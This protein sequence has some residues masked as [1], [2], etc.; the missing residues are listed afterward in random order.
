MA[1][2]Q[3]LRPEYPHRAKAISGIELPMKRS[4]FPFVVIAA[5]LPTASPILAVSPENWFTRTGEHESFFMRV[6]IGGVQTRS[7]EYSGELGKQTS[8]A[9]NAFRVWMGWALLPKWIVHVS[10]MDLVAETDGGESTAPVW[11]PGLTTYLPKGNVFV[12]GQMGF[13]PLFLGL[14]AQAGKRWT[15][16]L[17]KEIQVS[18]NNGVG[19]MLTYDGGWWKDP[20]TGERWNLGAPGV[21]FVWTVN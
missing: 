13:S 11:G 17:G 3:D 7:M 21:Q 2:L 14:G 1:N 5:M 6:A 10:M 4:A 20:D 15:L 18:K 16:A 9:T 12:S 8:S 19:A